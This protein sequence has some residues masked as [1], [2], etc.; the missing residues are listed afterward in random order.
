MPHILVESVEVVRL[1]PKERVQQRVDLRSVQQCGFDSTMEQ[2]DDI[3]EQMRASEH[4]VEQVMEEINE[5]VKLI[6]QERLLPRDS[7]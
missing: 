2:I 4:A 3:S 7:D 1:T 6:T 5:T